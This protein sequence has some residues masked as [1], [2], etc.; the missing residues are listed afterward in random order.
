[1]SKKVIGVIGGMGPLATVDLF[2]KIAEHTDAASDQEHPRTV[3]D[4]NTD[5]PDRTAA[6]LRGG[7]DPVPELV[8]SAK[9]LVAAGAELLVMPCNTA[10][11]FYDA[12]A[13]AAGV[14]VL[15]M[16]A[17]TRS[18]LQ[19][20]GVT[21]AGLLATDGTIQAGIYQRTFAGSG[22]ELLTPDETGQAAVMAL[23]YDGVKAG[24]PGYDVAAFRGVCESLLARGAQTLIL[25]CTELPC[26]FDVYRLPYPHADPT[27]ELALGAIRAAGCK[28]KNVPVQNPQGSAQV[29]ELTTLP[30]RPDGRTDAPCS[31]FFPTYTPPEK[32]D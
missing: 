16:I 19:R 14:P 29:E 5:I 11:C 20:R 31:V 13:A 18:A 25:G 4:S 8:K 28:T 2:R 9:R 17:L 23:I 7:A 24:D 10:H 26:A 22:I 15:H 27:L 32:T 1:M 12:V 21:K 6:L 30:A 3:I